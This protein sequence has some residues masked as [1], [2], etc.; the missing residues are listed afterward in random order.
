MP[1]VW[2]STPST[3]GGGGGTG[4]GRDPGSPE[5]NQ[6]EQYPSL[7]YLSN[8]PSSP[9]PGLSNLSPSHAGPSGSATPQPQA[10]SGYFPEVPSPRSRDVHD[11]HTQSA[12]KALLRLELQG[13]FV[14]DDELG[15]DTEEENVFRFFNPA[16][17]SNIAVQLRDKVVR[18]VFI[19]SSR[20]HTSRSLT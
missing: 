7:A 19:R 20:T 5:Q 9:A 17:L 3:A 16:L 8:H 12:E 2:E 4:K 11:E 6:E 13:R 18:C 1:E 10:R 14:Y 15:G